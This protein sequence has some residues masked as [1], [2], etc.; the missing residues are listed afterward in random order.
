M[1]FAAVP[2]AGSGNRGSR[3]PRAAGHCA[4]AGLQGER[5]G[6]LRRRVQEVGVRPSRGARDG[7]GG[8]QG[9]TLGMLPCMRPALHTPRHPSRSCRA[10]A[11][12]NTRSQNATQHANLAGGGDPHHAAQAPPQGGGAAAA[13]AAGALHARGAGRAGGAVPLLHPAVD[14]GGAQC[15]RGMSCLLSAARTAA[16]LLA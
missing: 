6:L 10:P 5:V 4:P 12:R 15:F 13:A 7:A 9:A 3:G 16:T 14:C 1:C 8:V 11:K 2:A